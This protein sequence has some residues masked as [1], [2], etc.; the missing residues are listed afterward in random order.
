MPVS[1]LIQF[2]LSAASMTSRLTIMVPSAVV[3]SFSSASRSLSLKILPRTRTVR[4]SPVGQ[5]TEKNLLT[6]SY[7]PT[8]WPQSVASSN[9]SFS[10][11]QIG[12][13]LGEPDFQACDFAW[14]RMLPYTCFHVEE[15]K[16]S[17]CRFSR[18]NGN[19]TSLLASR[20]SII[21]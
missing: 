18:K 16:G 17:S 7:T 6:P 3:S 13:R 9:C 15:H 14:Q 19:V 2:H 21:G 12:G 1:Q 4:T 5:L 8:V 10:H 11:H 20:R